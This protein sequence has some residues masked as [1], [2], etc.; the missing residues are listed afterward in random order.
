MQAQ[1]VTGPEVVVGGVDRNFG[2]ESYADE[3]GLAFMLNS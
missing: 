1:L 3:A 2:N